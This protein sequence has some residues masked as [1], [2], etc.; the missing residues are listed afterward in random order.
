MY[1]LVLYVPF[2]SAVVSGIYGRYLGI[3]G[4]G[5]FT[6]ICVLISFCVASLI[7]YETI[8]VSSV[9]YVKLWKWFECDLISSSIGFQFD[10]L[11]SIMLLVITCISLLVHIYSTGYMSQDPHLPRFMC[12]L[13]LFTFLMTLLVSSDNYVQ[14]FIG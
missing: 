13:S 8:L 9:T 6:C 7:F 11:T 14:L 10:S 12:Y 5:L 1:L 2:L 3:L 4:T